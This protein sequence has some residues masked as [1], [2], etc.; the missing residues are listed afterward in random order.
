MFCPQNTGR[1]ASPADFIV[2]TQRSS[3]HKFG[4]MTEQFDDAEEQSTIDAAASPG[5]PW[6]AVK[7][8]RRAIA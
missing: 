4:T 3:K 5:Q 8:F 7:M 6:I 2:A 1:V